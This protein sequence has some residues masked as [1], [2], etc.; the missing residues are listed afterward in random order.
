MVDSYFLFSMLVLV[1]PGIVLIFFIGAQ[2]VL[3]FGYVTKTALITHPR[4][5]TAEQ[6]LG[7]IK[8]ACFSHWFPSKQAAGVAEDFGRRHS[9]D[10]SP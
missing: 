9:W 4:F 1:L 5:A 3:C 7:S 10:S 6:N 2:R 8:A